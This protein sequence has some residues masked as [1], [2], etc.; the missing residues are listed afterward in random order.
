MSDI[1]Y[2]GGAT[3]K[4]RHAGGS[5]AAREG[6][7]AAGARATGAQGAAPARADGGPGASRGAS[8]VPRASGR[9]RPAARRAS[10]PQPAPGVRAPINA[11]AAAKRAAR[12]KPGEDEERLRAEAAGT[13]RA[14]RCRGGAAAPAG[15]GANRAV[16][17]AAVAIGALLAVL[18]VFVLGNALVGTLLSDSGREPVIS[19][20]AS[21]ENQAA[22]V[23]PADPG[24]AAIVY[25]SRRYAVAA[26]QDG[27]YVLTRGDAVAGGDVLTLFTLAGSP[28][29]IA[30]Y[31]GTLYAVSNLDGG[32]AVQAFVEGDGSIPTTI[33]EGD[34]TV[35]G[36]ALDGEQLELTIDTGQI[37]T[38]DLASR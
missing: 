6:T 23:D 34:G 29:G 22:T 12:V 13:V 14:P 19:A 15:A 21:A 20:Q 9:Q 38:I 8:G 11:A 24:A 30:C 32:Y 2:E 10:A 35:T 4:P 16:T 25:G 28:A 36:V 1:R 31:D 3:P 26:A 5:A 37:G 33:A 17:G 27:S 7:P 18:A